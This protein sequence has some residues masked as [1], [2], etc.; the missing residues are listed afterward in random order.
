[1][2]KL[3]PLTKQMKIYLVLVGIGLVVSYNIY[4]H[5]N[6]MPGHQTPFLITCLTMPFAYSTT[7]GSEWY[8]KPSFQFDWEPLRL[9]TQTLPYSE[10]IDHFT[11][12]SELT[13]YFKIPEEEEMISLEKDNVYQPNLPTPVKAE[14]DLNKLNDPNYL[15][16]KIYTGDHDELT[17]DANMLSEW[18]FEALA[19]KEFRLDESIEGPKVLIFHTHAKERFADE[20]KSDP[21][22]L[23]V[24]SEIENIL[25]NKYGIETLHVTDHFYINDTSEDTNGCY[26]RMETVIQGILD[27]NPS[28]QVC[29]DLHRDGVAGTGK[30]V[31]DLNGEEA[32]KIMFVNGLT[33]LKNQDGENIPM[34]TLTNPNLEDNLAFSLQAQIEG[35]KYYP[36]LMRKV[37]LKAYRYSLHM[38]PMSLLVEIGSQN[39]T[40]EEAVRT[41]EPIATILAKVLEKD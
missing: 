40:S 33:M 11:E 30:V 18:D 10:F 34:K 7:E 3:K 2:Q 41:A 35:M 29:I 12:V 26:E 39:D 21:G 8:E 5:F 17:I 13:G 28:I 20:D 37:Y 31:G 15:L 14:I 27:E 19:K 6:K 22:I 38:K 4:Q 23:A 25:E 32:C 36:E 24:G 9:L 16:S 1:M